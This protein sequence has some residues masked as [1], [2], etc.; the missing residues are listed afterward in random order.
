MANYD[1]VKT[2]IVALLGTLGY[3]EADQV[4]N[5][6]NASEHEYGN[7]FILTPQ[8]G[9]MD[10]EN[11]ETIIDRFYDIQSWQIQIAFE[12]SSNTDIINRD[13]LHRSK[14][15]LLKK[16]DKP[17]NWSSFV[18]ILKYRSWEVQNFQNYFVLVVNLKIVDTY[19]YA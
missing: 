6:E 4:D 17:A 14:D 5:F 10:D 7:K 16:L 1:T 12:R 18:R 9:E 15:A 2:G 19:V 8:A 13:N 3:Q 11:S